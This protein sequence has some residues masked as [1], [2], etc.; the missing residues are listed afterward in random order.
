MNNKSKILFLNIFLIIHLT[1][2]FTFAQN[3]KLSEIMFAPSSENSEFIEIKNISNTD[4]IDLS[5]FKIKYH[6]TTSDAIISQNNNYQ[7]LPNQYAIIF[8]ADYDFQNGIYKELI[9][10]DVL[11]F[12]LDDN[13][14]G[15][16]GMANTSD[17]SIYLLNS[18]DDT[19]DSYTYTSDNNL[20]FSDERILI[21]SN[22]WKNSIVLNGTP[23][24]KNSAS[25]K[26]F[27]LSI[28]E[29]TFSNYNVII[30][31][32]VS[33]NIK[34]E[35]LGTKLAQQFILN[36]FKDENKDSVHQSNEHILTKTLTNLD[37][38]KSI[39]LEEI[40][41]NITKGENHFIA[42]LVFANDEFTANNYCYKSVNGI[43]INEFRGDIIINEIMFAPLNA[44]TEW[45]ELYNKSEK[46]IFINNYKIA[47]QNDTLT[48]TSSFLLKPKE[49]LVI[50]ENNIINE[51]Y[52]DLKNLLI[53]D[54]PTLNNTTDKI[55]LMDSLFRVID[56][57]AYSSTWGG[58]NG[59][60]LERID[61]NDDSNNPANWKN[62]N[63]PT[64]GKFNSVSL[65]E[66]DLKIDL[67]EFIFNNTA[68]GEKVLLSAKVK[69][70][71][72]QNCNFSIQL[73]GDKNL[74]FI[75]DDLIEESQMFSINSNDSTNITFNHST[76]FNESKQ[77][78]FVKLNV[79]DD[80]STNNFAWIKIYPGYEKSAI[81]INE[82]MYSPINDEPEWI[83][84][85]NNSENG[86]NLNKFVLEDGSSAITIYK[87]DL[88]VEPQNYFV[89][90]DDSS[91]FDY[92]P[93][94][95]NAAI[96]NLPSLNNSTDK[97]IIR[98]SL[99][100]MIDSLE[101][102]SDWGGINGKS[103]E[104]IN[105]E[106][107]SFDQLNWDESKFPTPG[108]INSISQKNRDLQIESISI[109][110]QN[111]IVNDSVTISCK[112]KNI[113]KEE[114]LFSIQIYLIEENGNKIN[115]VEES[116]QNIL[117]ISD[118]LNFSFATKIII[119]V[120]SQNYLVLLNVID[121]DST[122]N[123]IKFALNPGYAK[124]SIIVNEIM[125]SPLNDE[126]EWIE[127][128]NNSDYNIDLNNWQIGDVLTK[129]I[130]KEISSEKFN[131]N[132]KTFLVI[133]KDS[134]INNFHKMILSPI[135]ISKFANLNN[136]EDGIVIKDNRGITIDSV[137]Y[138]NEF[139][140]NGFSIERIEKNINSTSLNNWK[141]S[142][143]IEGST[144]GRVNSISSKNIDVAVSSL[145]SIPNKP[146]TNENI[147]I[148]MLL[149]NYGEID[150][151]N[152]KVKFFF[153]KVSA[154]NFLE[155]IIIDKIDSQD[156]IIVESKNQIGIEDTLFISVKVELANDEDIIN[157]FIE[158][159][160]VAGFNQNC[161]LIN[162]IMINPSQNFP[163][164][165]ELINNSDSTINLKNWLIRNGNQTLIIT[166]N[167][168][169]IS[170]NEFII[171]TENADSNNFNLE[172]NFI[173]S[174]L[175]DL[176]KKK[177]KIAIYDYR[178][179]M[180][181]SMSYS[182]TEEIK[183]N[184]SLERISLEM[185]SSEKSNWTNCLNSLGSTP[186]N[187][188]SILTIPKNNFSDLIITEIMFDPNENNSE[189]IEIFNT[190]ESP[191]ELGGWKIKVDENLF[192]LSDYSFI[193]NE[194]NYF[195]ISSDSSIVKNYSWL[196]EFENLKIKNISSFGL[197]NTGKKIYLIDNR[198]VIIDS[199]YYSETWHNS[200]F[201]NVKNISLELINVELDRAKSINWS[202]SVSSF[203]GTPGKQ[204]SI[205]INKEIS[206]SKLNISPN[207]FSPDNDG[208]EDFT[209]ISYNLSE[210]ISQIRLRIY[211]SKG[212]L[213]RNL[214]NNLSVGSS[215]EIIFDGLD[216]KKNQL[217]IGIYIVLFEAVNSRN[218]V[219]ETIKDVIV[220]ARK[221]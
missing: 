212:R 24:F 47:D 40:I 220:V 45:I 113:G 67:A 135:I 100:R 119:K 41:S 150:A 20:G 149:K 118:S 166:Q 154:I 127:I 98:D 203:G 147:K 71:G 201:E 217:K 57:V 81:I 167:D 95:K 206:K 83:E 177:D 17:R 6:T 174:K 37:S 93:E 151:E 68:I 221:F 180:I 110:P 44:E 26:E 39:I 192:S 204:N 23:G 63:Y 205:F 208:Y 16:T 207:P 144:P 88:K 193:L 199:I 172:T 76:I 184:I 99:L 38:S 66:F 72:R 84:L 7:L 34:I 179:A 188:N 181:D 209:I 78:F 162:E 143:D 46:N 198:N 70:I 55:I 168:F 219:V 56:S 9:P 25:P 102:F 213:V 211:D 15:S 42:E 105:P 86:I 33:I 123:S 141:S 10:A 159:I 153:G 187:I 82:I 51:I 77:N 136:D 58:N 116:V 64:P 50:S 1:A 53:T 137:L 97:I 165:I 169:K 52:P 121:D 170:P 31:N 139:S 195:V 74:D 13:A 90:A 11:L 3:V 5:G 8:E 161:Q 107:V 30:G 48:T 69:N 129:P 115:F 194:N 130:F 197:T 145:F 87:D 133:A 185:E 216:E 4:T 19:L 186:G 28:K 164:W 156:S 94:V 103:L 65:K 75:E 148:K 106:K 62:S 214:E 210:P 146:I 215:G 183:N 60:S 173:I 175:P 18:V 85:F 29:I 59:N 124:S 27:D 176:N 92:Y 22:N 160:I 96:I 196:H 54:L 114:I 126:P 157:N 171:I 152:V 111:Y 163:Q 155:E 122:N 2:S 202:S 80:D 131:F 49:Y 190:T 200:A 112:I 125:F 35:N 43:E 132:S 61:V 36:L 182:F 140:K 178:N 189:Y 142:M 91:F 120:S 104:R 21:E 73:F 12:L 128:Y 89:I 101:Y 108:R 138:T 158:K 79:I 218:A 117:A 32:E 14:F 191:I 134:T 109:S